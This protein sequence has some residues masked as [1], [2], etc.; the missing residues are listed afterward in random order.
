[1]ITTREAQREAAF[2]SWWETHGQPY[3]D[4]VLERGGTPWTLDIDERRDLWMRRYTRPAPPE[5]LRI[6]PRLP[7]SY[8]TGAVSDSERLSSL[9]GNLVTPQE[10]SASERHSSTTQKVAA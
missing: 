4:A 5:G 7:E 2:Q 3:Q 1:M 9:P 8:A 6:D 10:L